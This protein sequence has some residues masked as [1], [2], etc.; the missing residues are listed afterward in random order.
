MSYISYHLG[1][2]LGKQNDYTA[3]CFLQ[4]KT[5]LDVKSRICGEPSFEVLMMKRFLL[6]TNYVSIVQSISERLSKHPF[7][8]HL[9][10][11]GEPICRPV[12]TFMSF[13]KTGVGSSVGELLTNDEFLSQRLKR[14]YAVNIT[15]GREPSENGDDLNIPKR[16]LIM[17]CLIAFE[18]GFLRFAGDMPELPLLID[19]LQNFEMKFTAKGNDTYSAK[20]SNHDDM[21]L[22]LSLAVWS[23]QNSPDIDDGGLALKQ[24]MLWNGKNAHRYPNHRRRR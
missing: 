13:D 21:V 12:P 10:I 6:K 22:S 3:V 24:A 15:G 5:P 9:N 7:D 17:N 19:E 1:C 14:L 23:A 2:D 20:G 11:L 16:D 18:R 4:K 8:S